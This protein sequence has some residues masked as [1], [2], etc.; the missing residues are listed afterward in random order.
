MIAVH[1]AV[2]DVLAALVVAASPLVTSHAPIDGGWL[3]ARPP[4]S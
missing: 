4:L 3:N 1:L 2:G